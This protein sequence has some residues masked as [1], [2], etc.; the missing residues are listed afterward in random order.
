LPSLP[1]PDGRY[2]HAIE[3][4][5]VEVVGQQMLHLHIPAYTMQWNQ[6]QL[7]RV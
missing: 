3:Q 6:L 7:V 5:R 4:L 1:K 2:G